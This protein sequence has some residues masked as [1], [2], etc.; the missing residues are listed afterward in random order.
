LEKDK[1]EWAARVYGFV[2][3]CITGLLLFAAVYLVLVIGWRIAYLIYQRGDGGAAFLALVFLAI[4][5][6][7]AYG[8]RGRPK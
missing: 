2:G 4:L 7:I 8:E 3:Y 1:A 6:A 5:A